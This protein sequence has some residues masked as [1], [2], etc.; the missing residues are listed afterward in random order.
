MRGDLVESFVSQFMW[1]DHRQNWHVLY[2]RM[3]DNGTTTLPY[4][5]GSGADKGAEGGWSGGHAFSR[6]RAQPSR[7]LPL[8]LASS[9]VPM[10]C[11]VPWKDGIKWSTISRAYNTSVPLADGSSVRFVSRE[12]PKLLMGKDGQPAFLSNAVQPKQKAGPDSG[13]THTLVVPLNV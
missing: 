4:G 5:Q 7:A 3:F 1:I 8:A 11:Y 10:T 12:R 2:H 13:V 6:V 9:T